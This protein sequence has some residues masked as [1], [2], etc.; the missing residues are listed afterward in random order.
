MPIFIIG[1][2]RSGT[3]MLR[4]LLKIHPQVIGELHEQ[5][6]VWSFGNRHRASK[7]LNARDVTPKIRRYIR[8][9]FENKK[10]KNPDKVIVDKNVANSLRVGFVHEIFP[11]SPIIH[12]I[13][14]GRDALCSARI[15]WQNTLD[16]KYI[17]ENKILKNRDFPIKELP[18]FI[19]RE[20]KWKL[21]KLISRKKHVKWWGPK[22]D[23]IEILSKNYTLTELCGI[24]WSRCVESTLQGLEGLDQ[25][26]C[27]TVKYEDLVIKPEECMK[28]ICEFLSLPFNKALGD[29]FSQYTNSS[30]IGR[31]KKDLT[32][33]EL[34]LLD[35]HIGN[36][37]AK[38]GYTN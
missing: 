2:P 33:E 17:L 23:D 8:N 37:L 15:R 26:L 35:R 3:K 12:I 7:A 38:T 1:A 21:Q 14:D 34:T 22:F 4:E 9:H 29:E 20:L 10:A 36:T 24:Q 13:R 25:K 6:R 18:F 27:H 11:S 19:Q 31:W 28:E 16:I 30:S 32:S 5:E